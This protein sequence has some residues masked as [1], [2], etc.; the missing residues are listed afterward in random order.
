MES[1]FVALV[2]FIAE[3]QLHRNLVE[4]ESLP[5]AIDEIPLIG[6]V[7]PLTAVG[8]DHEFGRPGSDLRGVI[9]FQPL[10]LVNRR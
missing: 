4:S 8:H 9:K 1:G 7:D 6:K 3:D 2:G 10:I 5:I